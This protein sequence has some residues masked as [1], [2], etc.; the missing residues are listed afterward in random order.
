M[1]RGNKAFGENVRWVRQRLGMTQTALAAMVHLNHH[2]PTPSYISRLESGSI[3][4][5]LSTVHSIARALRVKPWQLVAGLADNVEFWRGYLDLSPIQKRE[6][7]RLIA[8][9]LEKR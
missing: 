7:Q 4:P 6:I 9:M 5:R 2:H 8:R 3:D 1:P